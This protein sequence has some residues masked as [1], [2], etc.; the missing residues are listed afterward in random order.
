MNWIIREGCTQMYS[1]ISIW[2]LNVNSGHSLHNTI[3]LTSYISS[4]HSEGG[5]SCWKTLPV[6]NTI[7]NISQSILIRRAETLARFIVELITVWVPTILIKYALRTPLRL[8]LLSIIVI[9]FR[10]GTGIYVSKFPCYQNI[11]RQ[12]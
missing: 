4:L 2:Y 9:S 11:K 5:L 10:P 3:C 12:E 6:Q 1:I 7:C 8:V